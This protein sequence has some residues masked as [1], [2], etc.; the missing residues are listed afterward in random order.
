MLLKTQTIMT[1]YNLCQLGST[2]FILFETNIG[3]K[4]NQV[5]NTT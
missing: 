2:T 5:V 3:N 4:L 1:S